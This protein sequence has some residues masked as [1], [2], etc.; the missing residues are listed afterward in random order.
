MVR[1]L[2]AAAAAAV[3]VVGV[4]AGIWWTEHSREAPAFSVAD[5]A[6][7]LAGK[8][9]DPAKIAWS[10]TMRGGGGN[11]GQATEKLA[12]QT[13][14]AVLNLQVALDSN[15]KDASGQAAAQ[16]CSVLGISGER[17]RRDGAPVSLQFPYLDAAIRTF[18][19]ELPGKLQKGAPGTYA[20][21]AAKNA[22]D[23]RRSGYFEGEEG[24]YFDLGA[25]AEAGR[26]AIRAKVPSFFQREDAAD[27]LEQLKKNKDKDKEA[28]LPTEVV[29][30]L[31]TVNAARSKDKLTADDYGALK[32]AFEQILKHYYP[33]GHA[34]EEF[35]ATG[36]PS[37][38]PG[39]PGT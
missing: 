36:K 22:Q 1:P 19:G 18:Y 26:F 30:A 13:G 7:P 38:E 4:G 32:S 31:E 23:L 33:E 24:T 28:D 12:V 25:W 3:L 14:V 10:E 8:V 29:K 27:L 5:L 20:S 6:K 15:D 39:L 9:A 35:P 16:V 2:W 34:D 21:E 17:D 37:P 11:K